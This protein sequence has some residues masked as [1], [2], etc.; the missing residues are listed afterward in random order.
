[1]SLYPRI[2]KT[3]SDSEA[4][5]VARWTALVS[6]DVHTEVTERMQ[7]RSFF[8]C[9]LFISMNETVNIQASHVLFKLTSVKMCI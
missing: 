5:A 6:T 3:E 2:Y 9:P 7:C 8:K 4:P 1:M